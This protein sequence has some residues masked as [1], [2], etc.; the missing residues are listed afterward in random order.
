VLDLKPSSAAEAPRRDGGWKRGGRAC[1]QLF[2]GTELRAGGQL[3]L[4]LR[5]SHG[6]V[7]LHCNLGASPSAMAVSVCILTPVSTL[8]YSDADADAVMA[9]MEMAM[10]KARGVAANGIVTETETETAIK[11]EVEVEVADG[12][13]LGSGMAQRSISPLA[14]V[15]SL[16]GNRSGTALQWRDGKGWHSRWWL[17][18]VCCWFFVGA[19]ELPMVVRPGHWP[20]VEGGGF[21]A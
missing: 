14:A 8:L 20:C 3:Q 21:G 1:H 18:R 9:E 19:G 11:V 15:S 13:D 17:P 10:A 5:W 6:P 7:E 4:F 12:K 2:A 16:Q